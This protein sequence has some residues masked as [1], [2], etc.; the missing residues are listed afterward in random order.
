[1]TQLVA[2][3]P[4]ASARVDAESAADLAARIH[5]PRRLPIRYDGQPMRHLSNSSYTRFLLC[6]EDWRRWYLKGERPPPSGAM[7][8]GARVDDALTLYYRRQLEHGDALA[9]DQVADAYRDRWQAELAAAN[10]DR[11]IDWDDG[12][13]ESRA[14]ELGRDALTL[15]LSELVPRLGRPVAVQRKLEFALAPDLEWTIQCYLDLETE[16]TDEHGESAP[17]VIDYKVKTTTITQAKADC[18]PQAGLY[19]AARWLEGQ[20]RASSASRRSPS[21]G[22]GASRWPPRSSPRPAPSASS[23]P[24]S[25]GS[26][27]PPAR[28]P[29]ITRALRP[30]P[31]V[32]IRRPHRLEVRTALLRALAHLPRR[33][34]PLARPVRRP[35]VPMHEGPADAHRGPRARIEN[36]LTRP[37]PRRVGT[38]HRSQAEPAHP[39]LS[40][41]DPG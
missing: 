7:F 3:S 32:G 20:P 31:P 19:L 13:D 17:A 27:R 33:H 38:Y 39:L 30:R 34:R 15:T 4:S 22:R 9:P 12:P 37:D 1:M 25:R 16:R 5:V 24:P 36:L 26:R 10:N 35:A 28:S 18:D 11:G 2:A 41:A 8:L 29:P 14:C 6:P 23:E 40:V 21:P